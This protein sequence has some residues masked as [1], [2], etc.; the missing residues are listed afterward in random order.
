MLMRMG[1]GGGEGGL[2]DLKFGTFI[3]RFP[4][5]GAARMALKGLIESPSS[6]LF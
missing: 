5:D 2:S 3:G 6:S 4:G 1:G